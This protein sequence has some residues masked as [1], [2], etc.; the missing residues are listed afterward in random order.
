MPNPFDPTAPVP[1][2]HQADGETAEFIRKL[3]AEGWTP[4]L[5][6]AQG[7]PSYRRTGDVRL[8]LYAREKEE[9]ILETHW[10]EEYYKVWCSQ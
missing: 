6:L 9:L 4:V 8:P 2:F 7:S 10:N 3:A 1:T 5:S